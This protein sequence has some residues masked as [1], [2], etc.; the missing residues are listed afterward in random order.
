MQKPR[1]PMKKLR[2]P[3]LVALAAVLALGAVPAVAGT[4]QNTFQVTA[5]VVPSCRFTTSVDLDFG[6]LDVYGFGT[7]LANGSVSVLCTKNG[8]YTI[9]LDNGVTP[10]GSGNRQMANGT[11]VLPYEIYQDQAT[12]SVWKD[13]ANALA[14]TGDGLVDSQTVY[15]VLVWTQD[16]LPNAPVGSY[17]DTVTATVSY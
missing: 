6:E 14:F 7:K 13:G 9:A 16:M 17:Q 8:S 11:A 12:T 2:I 4:D 15:G 10:D 5:S 3:L 1:S